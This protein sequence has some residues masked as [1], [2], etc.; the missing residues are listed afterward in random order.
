MLT[1]VALLL[2]THA[3]EG[4]QGLAHAW[5]ELYNWALYPKKDNFYLK[6][7]LFECPYECIAYV[8]EGIHTEARMWVLGTE[9]KSSGKAASVLNSWAFSPTL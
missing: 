3:G 8:C 4:I 6:E 1:Y 2:F 7:I 9:A 5:Q